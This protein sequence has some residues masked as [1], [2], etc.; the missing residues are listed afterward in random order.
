[1]KVIERAIE[2][3][4]KVHRGQTDKAGAPYILHPLRVMM[5]MQTENEMAAAVLHDVIEDTG[6]TLDDLRKTDLPK[7]VI[8][9]VDC[10]TRRSG[11]SY[12]TYIERILEHSIAHKIKIADLEDNMDLKRGIKFADRDYARLK[13]YHQAWSRLKEKL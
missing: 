7:T 4:V 13:K 8:E 3:A 5:R 9:T 12:D 11:E 2:I 1:M 10:L 6:M